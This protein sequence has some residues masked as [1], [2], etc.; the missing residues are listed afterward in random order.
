MGIEAA[1]R[2]SQYV[3]LN[4][5]WPLKT[6]HENRLIEFALRFDSDKMIGGSVCSC[7]RVSARVKV[8]RRPRDHD[9]S[10]G[11]YS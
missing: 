11:K 2:K 7:G 6:R 8:L 3:V 9:L 10:S 4:R 1:A 5:F